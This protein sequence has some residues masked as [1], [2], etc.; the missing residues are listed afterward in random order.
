M[1]FYTWCPSPL[2]IRT[3]LYTEGKYAITYAAGNLQQVHNKDHVTFRWVL[4]HLPG[5]EVSIHLSGNGYVRYASQ[6]RIPGILRHVKYLPYIRMN[7]YILIWLLVVRG[8]LRLKYARGV[9]HLLF[10]NKT[11]RV[12]NVG[13]G[14]PCVDNAPQYTTRHFFLY[15]VCLF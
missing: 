2:G 7:I 5:W 4:Q 13:S 11:A 1:H 14:T 15:F 10:C 8:S 9:R 6:Y 12:I 3:R